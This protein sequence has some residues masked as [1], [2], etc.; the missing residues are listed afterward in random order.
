MVSDHRASVSQKQKATCLCVARASVF[1]SRVYFFSLSIL[2]SAIRFI[3]RLTHTQRDTR[4]RDA[5]NECDKLRTVHSECMRL[6]P[7]L[8]SPSFIGVWSVP[9]FF[10]SI[11]CPDFTRG[12]PEI[13]KII[14]RRLSENLY[15]LSLSLLT[16]TLQTFN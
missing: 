12:K 2:R 11:I 9:S 15:S 1:I 7:G 14:M 16:A 10:V 5:P 4:A 3:L 8:D 13:E 6:R